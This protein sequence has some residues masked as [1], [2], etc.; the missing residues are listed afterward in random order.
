MKTLPLA[1]V[2]F[3]GGKSFAF[4]SVKFSPNQDLVVILLTLILGGR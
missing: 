1:T 4:K 3:P 2:A